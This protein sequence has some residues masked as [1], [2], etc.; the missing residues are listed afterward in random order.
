MKLLNPVGEET[1]ANTVYEP[2]ISDRNPE[3]NMNSS[4]EGVVK[5][6][7]AMKNNKSSGIDDLPA[8]VSKKNSL[9]R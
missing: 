1:S 7:K 9:F 4:R 3:S 8:E 5:A 2:I 6:M